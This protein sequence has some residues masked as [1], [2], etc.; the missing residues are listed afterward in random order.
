MTFKPLLA[1][2]V[3]DLTAVRF[4]V[5]ASPKLD[6]I[7]CLIR[8]GEAVSRTLKP[9]PNAHVRETLAGLPGLDGELIVGRP[10]WPDCFRR[11]TSGVMSRDGEPPFK[12]FVFDR[13]DIDGPFSERHEAAARLAGA[14]VHIVPHEVLHTPEALAEYESRMVAARYEGVMIRD[15][16]GAYKRGRSTL[17]DGILGKVKRFADT[18]GRVV[19]VEELHRNSN[20][21]G[22]DALGHVERSTAQAG[23]VPAGTLGALVVKAPEWPEPFRVGTGF[24]AASRALLWADRDALPGRLVKIKYQPGGSHDAPRFPVFLG[25]RAEGDA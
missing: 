20:E 24:D 6:G 12:Y 1:S 17:R 18:E 21:A 7:R 2:T 19:A 3:H 4:P 8:D 15:P 9:I 16:G 11:S 13:H 23:L 5:M 10:T 25:F 22:V 14:P